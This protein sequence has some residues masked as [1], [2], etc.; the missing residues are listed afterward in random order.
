[1]GIIRS[2]DPLQWNQVDGIVINESAPA[3]NVAGV[4]ANVAILVGTSQRG[5]QELKEITSMTMLKEVFGND[6]SKGLNKVLKGKAF[7]RLKF[8]RVV[9]TGAAKA[10][11]TFK[12]SLVDILTFTAKYKGAYGNSIKV[13]IEAGTTSGKKYT[14]SDTSSGAVLLDEV[15]DNVLVASLAA[16]NV[17]A[18]SKLVDV[19]VA[20]TSAEP[21]T[22]ALTALTAGA[23]GTVADTD[24]DDALVLAEVE[25]A[26]NVLFL[27]SYNQVRNGYLKVHATLTNDK[28]VICCG[29][30]SDEAS[31]AITAVANLRDTEGR[32]IYAFP[33]A[34]TMVDGVEVAQ[35]LAYWMASTISQTNPK[36]DPAYVDNSKYLAS[37]TRLNK[38]LSRA[39]HVL[40][41]QAGISAGEYDPDFGHK[42]KSG[43]VTQI[44]NSEKVTILRRRM[45]D[46]LTDSVAKFLKNYQ[47]APNTETNRKMAKAAVESFDKRLEKDGILP[48]DSE[49]SDGAKAKIIDIATVN[50]NDS[51]AAGFFK[52]LYRRR[53]YSSMRY[54]VL[55]AEIGQSVVVKEGSV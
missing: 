40:L 23:D 38:S 12:A 9:P 21:D 51:I 33:Y 49:M 41:V 14:I 18:A 11:K 46:F 31:D 22:A 26:G 5:P 36:I 13:K 3:P 45:T 24:Y 48:S 27:D 7:G 25:S 44:L 35:P 10:T 42:F 17:F 50:D 39:D 37:V 6:S 55:S 47:N 16:N 15:Y 1:M 8:I 29:A 4:A 28:M 34:Y 43:V 32:I 2:N 30:E 53:I 52:I 20:A 54:I 19:T